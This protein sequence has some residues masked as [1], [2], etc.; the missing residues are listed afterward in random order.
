[1]FAIINEQEILF[2]SLYLAL[3]NR[4][5]FGMDQDEEKRSMEGF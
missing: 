2:I 1:M 3:G 5:R 4:K